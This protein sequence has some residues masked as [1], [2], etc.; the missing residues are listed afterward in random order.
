YVVFDMQSKDAVVID[1]VLDYDPLSSST[2][3]SSVD[4]VMAFIDE[5]NLKLHYVLETHAHADHISGSQLLKKRYQVPVVIGHRITA[6]QDLFK[7]LFDLPASFPTDGSQFDRLVKEGDTLQAGS[8]R[9]SVIETPGHTPAC[10]THQLDDAVVTGR[11]IIM[12]D[13][14]T[15]RGA[16]PGVI[17]GL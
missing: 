17:A 3:T 1:P 12:E 13:V 2:S 14:G 8:L 10:G 9:V 4:K 16:L 11:A 5:Q 6:V 15:G 7:N